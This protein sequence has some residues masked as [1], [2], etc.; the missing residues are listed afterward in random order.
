MTGITVS[1]DQFDAIII[2]AHL[3]DQDGK[4][5]A[6]TQARVEAAMQLRMSGAAGQLILT[7]WAYRRDSSQPVAQAIRQSI[8]ANY[9]IHDTDILVSTS[10]RDTVGDAFFTRLEFND[11]LADKRVAVVTSDYHAQRAQMIFDFVY[12][13]FA[14][15][16]VRGAAV[17]SSP[18]ILAHEQR[19]CAAFT[20]TFTGV[21][22]GQM[23]QI[24]PALYARHPFYNG[25]VYEK[26]IWPSSTDSNRDQQETDSP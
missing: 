14:V 21:A 20:R 24:G 5:S 4:L 10:A 7:G 3:M 2:L 1:P 8:L 12:A 18:Q 26:M 15:A 13:D 17:S 22:P 16:D 23:E 9:D 25:D 19:S 11:Q 6:E